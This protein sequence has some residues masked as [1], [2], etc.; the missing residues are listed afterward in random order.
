MMALDDSEMLERNLSL[1]YC[2]GLHVVYVLLQYHAKVK[3]GLV[4]SRWRK[5]AVGVF[6]YIR[7]MGS[8]FQSYPLS[9]YGGH[10]Y[11]SCHYLVR[12]LR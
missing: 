10:I 9:R 12:G 2:T 1:R 4:S 5:I 8:S 3:L 11:L 7:Y 6:G